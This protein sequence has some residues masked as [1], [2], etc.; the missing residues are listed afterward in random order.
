M[1][2]A[3]QANL[4]VS[5]MNPQF[6]PPL[7]IT[8]NVYPVL[9]RPTVPL[10]YAP[11]THDRSSPPIHGVPLFPFG[12]PPEVAGTCTF[13]SPT[14]SKTCRRELQRLGSPKEQ[15]TELTFELAAQKNG[16]RIGVDHSKGT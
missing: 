10:R 8:P 5:R 2:A 13:N 11:Y 4:G 6:Y 3:N 9:V 16:I 15:V 7:P 12:P 1:L 14:T